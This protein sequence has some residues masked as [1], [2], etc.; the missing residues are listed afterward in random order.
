MF[1]G[2]RSVGLQTRVPPVESDDSCLSD[3]GDSDEDYTPPSGD[4]S[5]SS[6][7]NRSSSDED[8]K[9]QFSK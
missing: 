6:T 2:K 8:S 1:C 5:S 3:S 9:H 4:E 7:D